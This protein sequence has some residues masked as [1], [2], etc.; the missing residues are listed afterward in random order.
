MVGCSEPLPV[1]GRCWSDKLA[2][3]GHLCGTLLMPPSF[4]HFPPAADALIQR[5]IRREFKHCTVLTIAHRINT[6]LDSS[7][8]RRG[9]DPVGEAGRPMLCVTGG[10]VVC[11]SLQLALGNRKQVLLS[12]LSAI[13]LH[14]PTP[15]HSPAGAGDGGRRGQGV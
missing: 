4:S 10:M 12:F 8:V 15:P 2:C 3:P 1:H 14:T 13:I 6:I 7:K 5:T 9:G 11:P